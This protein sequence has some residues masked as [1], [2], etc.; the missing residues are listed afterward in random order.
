MLE[1]QACRGKLKWTF[2]LTHCVLEWGDEVILCICSGD[3]PIGMCARNKGVRVRL[4][5]TLKW[6]GQWK[7]TRCKWSVHPQKAVFTGIGES[8]SPENCWQC[9]LWII[10]SNWGNVVGKKCSCL[11]FYMSFLYA[12]STT[13]EILIPSLYWFG[14][15][16]QKQICK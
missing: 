14:G 10:Q 15:K 2:Q 9:V 1:R 11:I 13:K 12:L 8:I 16:K 5:S 4:S 7:I 6:S 3:E